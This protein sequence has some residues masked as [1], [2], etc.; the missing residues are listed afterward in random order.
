MVADPSLLHLGMNLI[1]WLLAVTSP[2]VINRM[3]GVALIHGSDWLSPR[4]AVCAL[5]SQV[6]HTHKQQILQSV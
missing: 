5:H 3:I 6:L 2:Q 1:A 4:H